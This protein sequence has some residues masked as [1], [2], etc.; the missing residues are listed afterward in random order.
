MKVIR[1]AR[2]DLS[3]D[4]PSMKTEVAALPDRWRPHFQRAHYDGEWTV[5]PLRS[6]GG[7]PDETMPFALGDAPA[8][9]AATPLLAHCPAIARFLALLKCPVMSARLLNLRRGAVIKPHR[10]AELAFESGQ[11]RMHLPIFTNP[12]VEFFIENERVL[13]EP[14]SCWYI[15]ANLTHRVANRGDSDR[16]HLVVDCAVDDWLRERFANA[17]VSYSEIRREA[18]ELRQMIELLR[19]MNTPVALALIAPLEEELS[20]AG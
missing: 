17:D 19:A 12:E 3:V 20:R 7:R 16:I 5:L 2:L 18:R 11:A 9:Y 15:N 1:C 13:M 8:Q 14:G 10:D 6:L 4:L